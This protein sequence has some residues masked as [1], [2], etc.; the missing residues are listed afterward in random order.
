LVATIESHV[1]KGV[2]KMVTERKYIPKA[3]GIRVR[4]LGVPKLE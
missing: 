1:S 4:S 2:T 3:D